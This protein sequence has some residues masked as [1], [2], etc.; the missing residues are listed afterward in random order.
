MNAYADHLADP[1]TVIGDL[2]ATLR[3]YKLLP[4]PTI[5]NSDSEPLTLADLPTSEEET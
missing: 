2:A 4:E 3:N 1:R 5:T